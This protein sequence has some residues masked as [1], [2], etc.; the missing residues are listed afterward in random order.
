MDFL[1]Q[2][3]AFG[4][5]LNIIEYIMSYLL[6]ILIKRFYRGFGSIVDNINRINGYP[7]GLGSF[8]WSMPW[9]HFFGASTVIDHCTNHYM[10]FQSCSMLLIT[11]LMLLN[12]LE[13]IAWFFTS[14]PICSVVTF[15]NSSSKNLTKMSKCGAKEQLRETTLGNKGGSSL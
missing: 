5:K 8:V 2:I 14:A 13:A 15:P 9:H 3:L 11:A 7:S 6:H 1:E 10:P 4:L 12:W